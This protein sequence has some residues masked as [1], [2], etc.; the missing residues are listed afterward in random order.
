MRVWIWVLEGLVNSANSRS[1]LP[2][3]P[4]PLLQEAM[5][6]VRIQALIK[7]DCSWAGTA[8][9]KPWPP[10]SKFNLQRTASS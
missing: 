1:F 3:L 10:S 9:L 2:Q 4:Q 8:K 7:L 5:K 6:Q